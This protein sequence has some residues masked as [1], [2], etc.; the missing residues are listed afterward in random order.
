[1]AL[2]TVLAAAVVPSIGQAAFAPGTRLHRTPAQPQAAPKATTRFRALGPSSVDTPYHYQETL[3]CS[4]CH[5]MHYSQQHEY[6]G[7]PGEGVPS[8]AGGPTPKLLR[9][10]TPLDLC[11]ACHDGRGGVPDVVASDTNGLTERAAG[12]FD[13]PEV[14]NYKGHNLKRDPGGLGDPGLCQ[15][16]HW[17]GMASAGVTCIDCHNPHGTG[18]YRNLQWASVPGSQPPIRAYIRPSSTG[19]PRYEAANV[20]YPAPGSGDT[21]YREV[22][23]ICIDC[24]HTFMSDSSGL[25]T[26]NSSPFKK[27][28]GTNTEWGWHSPINRTGANTDPSHW[29]SGTGNGFPPTG[30]P[31]L[32]FIVQGATTFSGATTV[33]SDNEVFCFS[34]HKAHGSE[35]AFSLRWAYGSGAPETSQAGCEQCHNK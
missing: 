13:N 31:R 8:L 15:R 11:L 4:D 3:N 16:C 22:T 14:S 19:L 2:V 7:A 33:A 32:P 18:H 28:P 23:N 24:H 26:G 29:V 12:F 27:H 9:R 10:G 1:M 30:I 34:C 35:N 21:S 5:T 25:Y 17:G 20:A 6:G